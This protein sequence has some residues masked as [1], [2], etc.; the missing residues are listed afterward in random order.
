M[1]C[2]SEEVDAAMKKMRQFMFEHV[3]LNPEAKGEEGKAEMLI[4]TL[5]DYYLHNIDLL[6]KEFKAIIDGGEHREIVVCDY[7]GAMTDRF[8]IAK[9]E[10]V[11]IPRC[12]HG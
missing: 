3:Y 8:A 10:E 1:V 6:P 12:W 7:I 5:Y 11:Y 9:Y 2:M 4:E